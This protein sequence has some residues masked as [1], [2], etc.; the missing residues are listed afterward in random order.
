MNKD[1]AFVSILTT[2]D[3]LPGLLV[4]NDSLKSVN[5]E[6]PLHVLLTPE[7][8]KKVTTVL[9]A[10]NIS[11]SRLFERIGNPTNV[12]INHRWFP[13]YSKLAVFNQTQ[14]NKIVY[15]DVDTLV[16]KNIDELFSCLHMSA[17]N[18]GSMLPRKSEPKDKSL[19][20]GLMVIEPSVDIYN[21]MI[22]KVGK[23]ENL[24]SAGTSDKP[25][26]G[27]DQDFIN[28]YYPSWSNTPNLHLDHK[29]NVFH[30]HLDEYNRFF[31]IGF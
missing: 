7:I 1:Y 24:E 29:F 3:Y 17:T 31:F 21:D 19:N 12:S 22:S 20:S 18:A 9:D 27:S 15:I 28:A 16:L 8:S 11:Y 25:V 13:T 26:A 14:Y 2:E 23:I 30:Y 5:S 4:L 10:H 6:Y